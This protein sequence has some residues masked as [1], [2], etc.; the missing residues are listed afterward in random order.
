MTA[1]YWEVGRRIVEFEQGGRGRAGYGEKL[2]QRLAAD[3]THTFGRG[4]GAVNLS[5]M[6]RSYQLW[7]PTRILQTPSE[8]STQRKIQTPSGLSPNSP[9]K[10]V[11]R[12]FP[13]P[14][15]HYVR[16]LSIEHANARAFY[17][18]EALR[19]G[20]SVR[21]LDRQISTL[22]YERTAHSRDKAAML[23][24]GDRA[25]PGDTLT[26]EEEIKDPLVLEFLAQTIHE[27]RCEAFETE[28]RRGFSQVRPTEAYSQ[29]VEEAEREKPRRARGWTT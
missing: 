25:K 21:Q 24:K 4:F 26:P 17:E 7:P 10:G 5:Q 3:L 16:L 19:G 28:A 27:C 23:T 11:P 29:S 2:L 13:L 14:W 20:W 1:T 18:A 22:F 6:R 12:T 8:Q 9:I 15:S